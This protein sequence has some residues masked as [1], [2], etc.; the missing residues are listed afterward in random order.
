MA[1]EFVVGDGFVYCVW[2]KPTVR[3]MDNVLHHV[4]KAAELYGHPIDYITRVPVDAPAP[5]AKV[6]NYLNSIM[7]N[8]I[9]QCASYHVVLEG[10]GFMAAVKRAVLVSLFQIGQ[11]RNLFFVHAKAE[12][13]LRHLNPEQQIALHGLFSRA[14]SRGLLRG[15]PPVSKAPIPVD[16]PS[17]GYKRS[18]VHDT[19]DLPMELRKARS[20]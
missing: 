17:G 12:E 20:K 2:G 4:T 15:A 6:R 1:C 8:I 7:P 16:M 18:G 14:D 5:D 11:R 13:V 10:T 3:D 9:E 19:R